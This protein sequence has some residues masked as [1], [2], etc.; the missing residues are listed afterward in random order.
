MQMFSSRCTANSEKLK[1]ISFVTELTT[2]N[3]DR[4]TSSRFVLI[5]RVYALLSYAV[6]DN[7]NRLDVFFLLQVNYTLYNNNNN[8]I[9]VVIVNCFLVFVCRL[10]LLTLDRC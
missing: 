9:V 3:K 1:S 4:L 5:A 10:R 7:E 6:V 8:N 2:L